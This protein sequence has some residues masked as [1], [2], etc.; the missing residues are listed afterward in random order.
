MFSDELRELY[1]D[2]FNKERKFSEYIPDYYPKVFFL[3]NEGKSIASLVAK[4]KLNDKQKKLI[5][6]LANL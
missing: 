1:W 4:E 5:R 6:T 3:S 2:V